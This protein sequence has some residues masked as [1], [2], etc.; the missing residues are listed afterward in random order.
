MSKL[1]APILIIAYNRSKNFKRL[2]D[3]I[4]FYKT[5]IYI[6]IDGPKNNFDKI[7]Q[8]KMM[9]L[10]KKNKKNYKINYRTLDKNLGCQK[11]VF[12]GLDWFFSYEEKGIILEDDCLPSPSFFKFCNKLLIRYKNNKKVF[13]ISG[14]TP[15][16][17]TEI[18]TDYF[19]SKIFMCWGWATWR[20]RWLIAKKFIPKER[21]IK[22]LKTKEWNLFLTSN[23]KKRYFN[24]VYNLI[25]SNKMDSWAFLW[26]LFGIANKSEFILPKYNLV[27]NT[28]TQTYGA[29]FIPSNFDYT[30]FK[31]F[32]FNIK[33]HPKKNSHDK[34][35]D[36]LLFYHNYRPK[37][38]LYPWRIIF[39]VKSLLFDTKFFFSKLIILIKKY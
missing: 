15:F 1:K 21:S 34:I 39:I 26:Q 36:S 8:F 23:I 9:N 5:K 6:S 24:K 16:I 2:I 17:K 28:G 7:E 30:N 18:D 32:Q 37:N 4:K 12:S 20:S 11:A 10:I 33:N 25:F 27:K 31:T 29:N 38:Q 22:L 14:Y 13:S 35:L 3:S 19:F